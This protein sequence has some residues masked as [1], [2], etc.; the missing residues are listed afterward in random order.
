[1]C[2]K[3]SFSCWLH[4]NEKD[5]IFFRTAAASKTIRGSRFVD[6]FWFVVLVFFFLG[7]LNILGQLIRMFTLL[8]PAGGGNSFRRVGSYSAKIHKSGFFGLGNRASVAVRDSW[9][10][11]TSE[12]N[13]C[14]RAGGLVRSAKLNVSVIVQNRVWRWFL[15]RFLWFWERNSNR[16]SLLVSLVRFRK[17][18]FLVSKSQSVTESLS[19]SFSPTFPQSVTSAVSQH[20]QKGI[21]KYC[22]FSRKTGFLLCFVST[23]TNISGPW[24]SNVVR[25]KTI[26][27]VYISGICMVSKLDLA[28]LPM[29]WHVFLFCA[30]PCQL[31]WAKTT[32][33]CLHLKQHLQGERKPGEIKKW[34]LSCKKIPFYS[35]ECF[36]HCCGSLLWLFLS[37]CPHFVAVVMYGVDLQFASC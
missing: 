24:I 33:L 12:G 23:I 10:S 16:S 8:I 1:M 27:S 31:R 9:N 26:G 22:K 3:G 28:C 35:P 30:Q 14:F 13:A 19:Q 21:S 6:H 15:H 18:W 20:R 5:V 2:H 17:R 11:N 4:K 29:F 32:K 34:K 25:L 36:V 7:E 37:F